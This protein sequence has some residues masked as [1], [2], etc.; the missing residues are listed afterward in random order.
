MTTLTVHLFNRTETT[1]HA[2][3]AEAMSRVH[4]ICIAQRCRVTDAGE[5]VAAGQVHNPGEP[6]IGI[7]AAGTIAGS[8]T[9]A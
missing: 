1:E 7:A 2:D 4:D 9:I 3:R 8:F 5:L 6:T